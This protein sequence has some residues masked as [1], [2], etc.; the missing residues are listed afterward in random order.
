MHTVVKQYWEESEAGWGVRP[1]GH[2]L[3]L[4]ESD[5]ESYI[6]DYWDRE[7]ERNP[8]GAVPDEYERPSGSG[9]LVD[10]DNETY[11]AIKASK[12][13]IRVFR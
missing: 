2:S 5:R 10:V 9:E 4:T 7:A 6:K 8:S 3:H 13:G 12:N 1:D 11:E